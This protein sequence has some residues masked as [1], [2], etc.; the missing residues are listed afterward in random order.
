MEQRLWDP[1]HCF[2]ALDQRLWALAQRLWVPNTAFGRP[3][4]AF[5]V[6]NSGFGFPNGAFDTVAILDGIVDIC[7]NACSSRDVFFY[8]IFAGFSSRAV[9]SS[10]SKDMII[11]ACHK[12]LMDIQ[13]SQMF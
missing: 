13:V 2:W 12:S 11:H 7:R 1:E 10:K 5:G 8:Y 4:I 6:P 3:N 9:F